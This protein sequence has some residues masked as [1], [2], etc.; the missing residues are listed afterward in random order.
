MAPLIEFRLCGS[1]I[2]TA[3]T[4]VLWRDLGD[5][6]HAR[7][8]DVVGEDVVGVVEEDGKG[9]HDDAEDEGSDAEVDVGVGEFG[10]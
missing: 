4:N 10:G 7:F 8:C 2:F 9:G 6:Q 3:S 5:G 1:G